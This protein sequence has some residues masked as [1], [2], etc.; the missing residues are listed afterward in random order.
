[1]AKFLDFPIVYGKL[2]NHPGLLSTE[3][4]VALFNAGMR[5]GP[6]CLLIEYWPD[7]GRSTVLLGAVAKNL[8]GQLKVFT[9][10]GV[11]SRDDERWFN[12]AFKA[13]G[14]AAVAAVNPPVSDTATQADLILLRAEFLPAA[15][16]CLSAKRLFLL[17]EASSIDGYRQVEAGRGFSVW[18][19]G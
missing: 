12:L 4:A 6:G 3:Q 16:G 1:M 19:A 10:W 14:L 9:A 7:G 15:N 17:G 18:E 8:E 5:C 13:H 2:G 11:P